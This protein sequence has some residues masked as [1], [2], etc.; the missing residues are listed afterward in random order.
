MRQRDVIYVA[1]ADSV[2]LEKFLNH[3]QAITSTVAGVTTD[4][5]I[6]KDTIKFWGKP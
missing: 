1:N 5:K 6:T 3:T 2:E 4:A